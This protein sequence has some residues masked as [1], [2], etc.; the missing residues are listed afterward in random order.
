MRLVKSRTLFSDS[1]FEKSEFVL[2]ALASKFASSYIVRYS[3]HIRSQTKILLSWIY[4]PFNLKDFRYLRF[5]GVNVSVGSVP[6]EENLS[7][8]SPI[9]LHH[10]FSS[11]S[12]SFVLLPT[13]GDRCTVYIS[14][15]KDKILSYFLYICALYFF[16]LWLLVHASDYYILDSCN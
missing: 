10:L 16:V 6:P 5:K 2:K 11:W 7:K 9:I 1:F 13:R 15:F 14:F 8:V 4:T 3:Y 12:I